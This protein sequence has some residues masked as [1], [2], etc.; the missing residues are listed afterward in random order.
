MMREPIDRPKPM[1][2]S[3]PSPSDTR[4][5][6]S[7]ARI[8]AEQE[9]RHCDRERRVLR[10]HEHVAVIQRAGGEQDERHEPRERPAEAPSDA[11][12]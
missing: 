3:A 1:P 5:Y 11:A 7:N 12:R 2:T 8:D 4:G 10:V 9:D 6:C